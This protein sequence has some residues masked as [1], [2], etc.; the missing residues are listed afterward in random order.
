MFVISALASGKHTAA[1]VE[2]G[3]LRVLGQVARRGVT[4]AELAQA[5]T[6]IE[7]GTMMSLQRVGARANLL[8]RYNLYKGDPN[9]LAKDLMRYRKAN[10][11]SV[12]AAA[13]RLVKDKGR[14]VIHVLP[15]TAKGGAR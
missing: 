13:Q 4:N 9:W 12:K 14:V 5:R 10:R 15:Q 2:A 3:L 11:R 6:A 7:T 8:Q 1:E